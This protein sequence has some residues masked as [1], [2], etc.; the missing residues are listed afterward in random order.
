MYGH[1]ALMSIQTRANKIF[2]THLLH[3]H[4]WDARLW[5]MT[6]YSMQKRRQH[7]QAT[8]FMSDLDDVNFPGTLVSPEHYR[9]DLTAKW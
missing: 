1:E 8:S 2:G 5:R 9:G 4:V 6:V 3:C 7:S